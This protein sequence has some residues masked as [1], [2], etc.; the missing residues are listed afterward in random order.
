MKKILQGLWLAA[1]C[2]GMAHKA[3][4]THY[5]AY[6]IQVFISCDSLPAARVGYTLTGNATQGYGY[7][8]MVN[9]SLLVHQRTVPC[10]KGNKGFSSKK[11]A[12]KVAALV[13]EKVKKGIMPPQVTIKEMRSLG[14]AL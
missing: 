13:A 12:A 14:I 2:S 7:D 1:V 3:M 10:V 9:G 5:T 11:D 6:A 4:A 8:V